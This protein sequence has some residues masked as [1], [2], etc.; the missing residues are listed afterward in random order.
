MPAPSSP[1]SRG[2]AP[3][4]R[5]APSRTLPSPAHAVFPYEHRT[6]GLLSWPHFLRRAARHVLWAAIVVAAAVAVGTTGYHVFGGLAWIDAFLNASMIMSGEGP[7]DRMASNGAKLF[8]AFY[9]LFS[10]LLLIVVMGVILTP[11]VHRLMHWMHL[12]QR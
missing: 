2:P 10:G 11:W 3:P 5:P 4:D 12:E 6:H 7:V 1:R 8:A 9:A